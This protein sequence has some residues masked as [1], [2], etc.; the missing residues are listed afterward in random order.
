MHVVDRD[1]QRVLPADAEEPARQGALER[2]AALARGIRPQADPR[3]SSALDDVTRALCESL[4][5]E[6][7]G[8]AR[9]TRR[10]HRPLRKKIQEFFS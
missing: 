8:D 1:Q 2:K 7:L 10:R 3:L 5:E 9:G 4:L 6:K